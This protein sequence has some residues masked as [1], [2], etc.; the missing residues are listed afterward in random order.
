MP[1]YTV[2]GSE[3]NYFRAEVEAESLEALYEMDNDD[4]PWVEY[5]GEAMQI[6]SVEL[7]GEKVG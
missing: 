5:D 2:Y 1:K 4:I 6:Y 7:N 3:V